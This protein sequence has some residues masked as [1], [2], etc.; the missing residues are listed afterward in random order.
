MPLNQKTRKAKGHC[1]M[2]GVTQCSG[3]SPQITFTHSLQ[4]KGQDL[5]MYFYVSESVL[6]SLPILIFLKEWIYLRVGIFAP[7]FFF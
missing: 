4:G 3:Q 7:F 1:P 5:L 6:I 2:G